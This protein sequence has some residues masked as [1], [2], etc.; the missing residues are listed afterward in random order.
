MKAT[1]HPQHISIG[2]RSMLRLWLISVN[3]S[4]KKTSLC[5]LLQSTLLARQV[6]TAF[7]ELH[8]LLSDHDYM[9]QQSV[10]AVP[11]QTVYLLLISQRYDTYEPN[12]YRLD[13]YN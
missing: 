12:I 7:N 3:P 11:S 5:L 6:P 2:Q 13:K 10:P 8:G 1:K 9:I 4:N